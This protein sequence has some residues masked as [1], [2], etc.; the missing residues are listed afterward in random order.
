[1][2]APLGRMEIGEITPAVS[3][4]LEFPPHPGLPFQQQHLC[5]RVVCRT[6]RRSHAGGTAANDSNY[7]CLCSFPCNH[8]CI[9]HII[10]LRHKKN[11]FSGE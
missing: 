10:P 4:C 3:G 1:M 6:D 5:I 8:S 7:H 11:F 9:I 2:V